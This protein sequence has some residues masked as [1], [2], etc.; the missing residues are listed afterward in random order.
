MRAEEHATP[1]RAKEDSENGIDCRN[2][3]QYDFIRSVS[4]GHWI[5]WRCFYSVYR[6][7]YI[8]TMWQ[9]GNVRLNVRGK[10]SGTHE[11]Q[12]AGSRYRTARVGH[13]HCRWAAEINQ[14]SDFHMTLCKA[15]GRLFQCWV[16]GKIVSLN[17]EDVSLILLL[18]KWIFGDMGCA[19]EMPMILDLEGTLWLTS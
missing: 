8:V 1:D 6:F 10:A 17:P 15:A 12:T 2:R 19:Q 13:C 4:R 9:L 14:N 11:T 5:Q 18:T 3:E 7:R 16:V